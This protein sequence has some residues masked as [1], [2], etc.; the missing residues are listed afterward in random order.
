MTFVKKMYCFDYTNYVVYVLTY[1]QIYWHI[2]C[3]RGG[4][5]FSIISWIQISKKILF[6]FFRNPRDD[7]TS[8]DKNCI[9]AKGTYSFYCYLNGPSF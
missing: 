1:I 5:G 3:C 9:Y 8:Q 2:L 7:K 6:N 4:E